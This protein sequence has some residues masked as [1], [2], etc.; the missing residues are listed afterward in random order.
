MV[1]ARAAHAAEGRKLA[2]AGAVS[3]PLPRHPP[4]VRASAA[5]RRPPAP[6]EGEDIILPRSNAPVTRVLVHKK[7][8][9][10]LLL[11][12]KGHIV[13]LYKIALGWSPV[14]DKH[15]EGDGRT[16]EGRYRI[17]ARN[18]N[19]KYYKSLRIS[20]P[21]RADVRSARRRGVSPGGNIFIHG[22]PNGKSWMWWKYGKGRDWT[23]G[24]IAVTDDE[25]N[26]IW[27]LVPD[28]T[29]IDIKP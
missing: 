8:R 20:Y 29:P 17:D 3:A 16:P 19:S 7:D 2:R 1:F 6:D 12:A 27:N 11:D 15:S 22:K 24:C 13:R 28:G 18:V 5:T 25:I 10:M 26:E 4:A 23:D 21:D 9:E 14:G